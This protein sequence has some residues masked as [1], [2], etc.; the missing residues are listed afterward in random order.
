MVRIGARVAI[1]KPLCKAESL[2]EIDLFVAAANVFVWQQVHLSI[3]S[4]GRTAYWCAMD[5]STRALSD[6]SDP[7][8]QPILV[9]RSNVC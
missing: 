6:V 1:C 3:R 7:V 4:T 5:P 9:P 2:I 8:I